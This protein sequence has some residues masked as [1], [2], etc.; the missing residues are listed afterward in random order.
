MFG[1]LYEISKKNDLQKGISFI[2]VFLVS[3]PF[4]QFLIANYLDDL[5]KRLKLRIVIKWKIL[6]FVCTRVMGN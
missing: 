3:L 4:I 1:L 5:F 6:V 2:D